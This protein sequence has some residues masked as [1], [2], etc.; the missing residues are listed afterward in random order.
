MLLLPATAGDASPGSS[1]AAEAAPEELST[2]ANVMPC[3]PMPFVPEEHH[4]ELVI[5][6]LVVYAGDAE[7]G[8]R[9]I[10]PFRALAT[11]ARRH[12][13]GRCRTPRCTRPRIPTTTRLAVARTMFIDRV[14]RRGRGRS[15]CTGS[16]RRTR[17]CASPSSASLGGAMARVPPTRPRSPTARAGS[18]S[19]SRRSTRARTTRPCSEAWVTEFA[20]RARAGRPRR[21]RQLPRRRR[22]GAHPRR[23]PGRDLGPARGDQGAATTRR[24]CSASTR[25]WRRQRRPGRRL[26]RRL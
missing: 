26:R 6:A 16:R 9:A 17:R 7:A 15:S 13:S 2:I 3:P 10:A 14:D 22:T 21:L 24:T 25:T 5:L 4:G 20:A 18:W 11:P 1:R 23:L 19:T 8:E 12:A